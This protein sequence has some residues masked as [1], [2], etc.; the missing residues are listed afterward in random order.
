MESVVVWIS[1][2]DGDRCA[3]CGAEIHAGKHVVPDEKAGTRRCLGCA[4][5]ADL[6]YLERGDAALTRR[7]SALS[8]RTGVVVL[9]SKRRKRFER[10]GT[11]VEEGA[12]REAE[13][14]CAADAAE[15]EARA[16]KR[17]VRD[18]EADRRYVQDFEA[19][20]RRYFPKC[21]A[22]EAAAI[23]R[24]ACEKHSGRVGR[25]A[26]AKELDAEAIELAVR[27]HVRH[28][29]TE[30]DRLRDEGLNKRESRPLVREEIDA[31][32]RR[33]R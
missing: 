16:A 21:P 20:V 32:L 30:Y 29:H 27:A 33:W 12:L 2:R 6:L 18:A 31:V 25:A 7:A 26:F 5:L 15:R 1:L 4:G 3:G 11:L 19:E 28:V 22:E 8:T 9:W 17:R 23:A 13:R 24:H 14:A 10:Q